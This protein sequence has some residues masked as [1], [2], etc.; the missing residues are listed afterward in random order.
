MELNLQL[1]GGRGASSSLNK[2]RNNTKLERVYTQY[3]YG[4]ELTG[5]KYRGYNIDVTDYQGQRNMMYGS[6]HRWYETK[7]QN[8]EGFASDRL[9]EMKEKLD[10]DVIENLTNR[11]RSK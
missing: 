8:G 4:K 2:E 7:L 9:K 11:K 10:K 5:Y 1:F 3:S 6:T